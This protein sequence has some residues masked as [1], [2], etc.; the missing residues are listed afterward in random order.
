MLSRRK[1]LASAA[2]VSGVAVAGVGPYLAMSQGSPAPTLDLHPLAQLLT[3]KPLDP[4]VV[5]RATSVITSQNPNFPAD[6]TALA[7]FIKT[8]N[9]ADIEALKVDP[10]FAGKMHDT[11]K[12]LISALYLGYVGTP[13]DASAHDG[14]QFVTFTDALTFRLTHD[15]TP[16]PSYSRWG[17]NYW[18]TVP[19]AA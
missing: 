7:G 8:N 15:F 3:G 19:K 17:T 18:T 16:I 10:R 6:A 14:V 5:A 9:I 11:A 1:L 2:V 13:G 4:W 12:L